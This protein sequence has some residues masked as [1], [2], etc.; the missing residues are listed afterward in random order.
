MLDGKLSKTGPKT[1]MVT[2][3]SA[4]STGLTGVSDEDI[5]PMETD[6]SGLIKFESRGQD[7]Y[8]VVRERI[9]D[10]VL[11]AA[12]GLGNREFATRVCNEYLR[13]WGG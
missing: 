6:H 13:T 12:R 3:K 9:R 2:R 4:T 11:G 5:V 8:I 10:F 1:L 7:A